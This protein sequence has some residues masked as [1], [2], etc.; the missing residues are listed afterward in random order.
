LRPAFGA[1]TNGR[2]RE[3]WITL[4]PGR[5]AFVHLRWTNWCGSRAD[6]VRIRLWFRTHEPLLRVRGSVTPP[7]CSEPAEDS[8]LA[9]A[10]LERA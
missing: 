8:V 2:R 3:R 1:T 4:A 10:P 9:I 7:P 5:R 6:P